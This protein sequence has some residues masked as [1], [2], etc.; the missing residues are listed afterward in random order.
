MTGRPLV[1]RV[2]DLVTAMYAA[3]SRGDSAATDALLSDDITI[4]DSAGGDLVVGLTGLAALRARRGEPSLSAAPPYREGALGI[5]ELRVTTVAGAIIAT[6][7][8]CV[9]AVGRDGVSGAPEISRNT[10]VLVDDAERLLIVHLHEDV[11]QPLGG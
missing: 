8:L 10:A 9:E 1:D 5:S 4:F 6:W 11:R 2:H 3:Y 7:W